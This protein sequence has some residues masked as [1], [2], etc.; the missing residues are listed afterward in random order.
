M[1]LSLPPCR[2]TI[3]ENSPGEISFE[4][5]NIRCSRKWGSPDLPGGL[6]AQPTLYQTQCATTGARWLATTTTSMP[7]SSVKV[8]GWKTPV[9]TGPSSPGVRARAG[10]GADLGSAMGAPL[11]TDQGLA[12]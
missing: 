4:P 6:S 11:S 9:G 1:A 5:L 2:A 8:S 10:A 12:A 3:F 7:L